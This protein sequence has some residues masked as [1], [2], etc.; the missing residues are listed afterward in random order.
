MASEVERKARLALKE[1]E[2]LKFRLEMRTATVSKDHEEAKNNAKVTAFLIGAGSLAHLLSQDWIAANLLGGAV[3]LTLVAAA[4]AYSY[5]LKS[6]GAKLNKADQDEAFYNLHQFQSDESIKRLLE[7]AIHNNW[8]AAPDLTA[9]ELKDISEDDWHFLDDPFFNIAGSRRLI[10]QH[11]PVTNILGS[12]VLKKYTQSNYSIENQHQVTIL[13]ALDDPNQ[14][15]IIGQTTEKEAVFGDITRF[16]QRAEAA[17]DEEKSYFKLDGAFNISN[18]ERAAIMNRNI[19]NVRLGYFS[20]LGFNN[21]A[22][23]ECIAN[24]IEPVDLEKLI[25]YSNAYTEID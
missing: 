21:A 3:G 25:S 4:V 13:Q 8:K 16:I 11:T 9:F 15:L 5:T 12:Y 22:I 17:I 23:E 19:R 6:R 18:E 10:P 20:R 1:L 7:L 2:E 14:A 24:E